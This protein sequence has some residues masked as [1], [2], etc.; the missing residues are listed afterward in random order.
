MCGRGRQVQEEAASWSGHSCPCGDS[1]PSKSTYPEANELRLRVQKPL[2][3]SWYL[4]L[5]LCCQGE[6][7]VGPPVASAASLAHPSLLLAGHHLQ[8]S[9]A[10]LG[11]RGHLGGLSYLDLS[12]LKWLSP[13]SVTCSLPEFCKKLV[14]VS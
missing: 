9:E 3:F 4:N 8:T 5:S 11:P 2:I 12:L 1:E 13:L 14:I 10:F 7:G 6:C